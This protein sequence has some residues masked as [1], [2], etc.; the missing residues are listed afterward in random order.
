MNPTR[1]ADQPLG[2]YY[3]SV[4]II[5][6][7]GEDNMVVK[8]AVLNEK[9]LF[10]SIY[11]LYPPKEERLREELDPG[12]VLVVREQQARYGEDMVQ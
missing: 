12:R 1:T 6:C 4:C 2:E 5:Q 9:Q 10:P 8:Y 3:P 11:R 7:T